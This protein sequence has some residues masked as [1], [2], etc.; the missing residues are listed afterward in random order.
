[1]KEE[2]FQTRLTKLISDRFVTDP[3]SVNL[4]STLEDAFV[5]NQL[6]EKD[7]MYFVGQDNPFD[8]ID[9]SDDR[10][11]KL[12]EYYNILN[13]EGVVTVPGSMGCDMCF[14]HFVMQIMLLEKWT[15]KNIK[16]VQHN[17]TEHMFYLCAGRIDISWMVFEN[18]KKMIDEMVNY[19]R[20]LA[21][22]AAKLD[23]TV[24]FACAQYSY[25]RLFYKGGHS[26]KRHIKE[27][28]STDERKYCTSCIGKGSKNKDSCGVNQ[29]DEQPNNID[30]QRSQDGK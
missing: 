11:E 1:M 24:E 17:A 27:G 21:E 20:H 2:H 15:G 22:V 7:W 19:P 13:N 9:E 30:T 10:I 18:S 28:I 29:K 16:I 12:N 23:F 5:N 25:I 3:V 4:R 8:T 14:Q 26:Y 6:T